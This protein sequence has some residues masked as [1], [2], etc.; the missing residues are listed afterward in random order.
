MQ[1]TNTKLQSAKWGEAVSY[2][3]SAE[4]GGITGAKCKMKGKRATFSY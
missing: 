4:Q 1:N 3:L 2:R